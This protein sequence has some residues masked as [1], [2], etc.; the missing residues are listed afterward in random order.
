MLEIIVYGR[1]K[2]LGM[3]YYLHILLERNIVKYTYTKW[4]IFLFKQIGIFAY[5][6]KCTGIHS[7]KDISLTISPFF[8][9]AFRTLRKSSKSNMIKILFTFQFCFYEK[10]VQ[11][12]TNLS[13]LND[14]RKEEKQLNVNVNVPLR[15]RSCKPYSGVHKLPVVH[16]LSEAQ[17]YP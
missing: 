14:L 10:S 2:N 1:M 12:K 17:A 6:F 13:L 9:L 8:P 16:M 5:I 7:D 4:E 11:N 3:L 15:L